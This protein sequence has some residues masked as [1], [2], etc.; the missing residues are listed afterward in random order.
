MKI[1][2]IQLNDLQKKR[3]GQAF[4][5]FVLTFVSSFGMNSFDLPNPPPLSA[6]LNVTQQAVYGFLSLAFFMGFILCAVF[7]GMLIQ[8]K[9]VRKNEYSSTI[10]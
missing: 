7:I 8:A 5:A 6:T 1:F 3:F 10:P 2:N 9:D 4:M